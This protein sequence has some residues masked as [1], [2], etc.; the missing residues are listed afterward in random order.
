MVGRI[1]VILVSIVSIIL[2]LDAD[3]TILN[4]VG[5]AWAGFGSSFG[6]LILFS[7]FWKRTTRQGALAGMLTG[8]FVV[9]LWKNYAAT[10]FGT[11]GTL[12]EMIPAF[13]LSALAIYI[14]SLMTPPP[15]EVIQREFDQMQDMVK[16][17]IK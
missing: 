5:Y 7:L 15:N 17:H 16:E 2:A 12:Y 13:F 1:T 8:A 9:I 3:D 10:L 6:P 14:V 11:F 4:L